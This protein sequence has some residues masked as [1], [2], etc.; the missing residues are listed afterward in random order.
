[1]TYSEDRELVRQ[2]LAR[3]I[4]EGYYPEKLWDR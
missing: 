1:M 3:K 4:A 2:A